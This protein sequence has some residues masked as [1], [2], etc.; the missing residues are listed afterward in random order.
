[1]TE[2]AKKS[3]QYQ[4]WTDIRVAVVKGMGQPVERRQC[5]KRWI[6]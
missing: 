5:R 1:M 6:Q 4:L 3:G 2:S